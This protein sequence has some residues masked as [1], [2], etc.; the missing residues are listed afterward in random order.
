MKAFLLSA[1]LGTRLKPI[2]DVIPKC[3]LT[4]HGKPLLY[5]WFKLFAE[6][7]ITE[8]LINLHHLPKRVIEGIARYSLWKF[9]ITIKLFYEP[10]LLG[11]AGT[12]KANAEWLNNEDF[13]IAYADNL[14][15]MDIGKMHK[16]HK[17]KN[18]I[19]TLWLYHSDVPKECG[20]ATLDSEDRIIEFIEKPIEPKSDL[21]SAGLYIATRGLFDY[22]PDGISDL[23][24]DVLPKM[25]ESG[26]AYGY[27]GKG[28]VRGVGTFDGYDKAEREWLIKES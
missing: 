19:L 11:T 13:L 10:S 18:G 27:T 9:G 16:Y 20:I 3:M 12:I 17:Q 4:V 25:I 1:G 6:F 21:G 5:H 22:I 8:V 15:D 14:T 24:I 7:G 26:K 2:T 28:Y 23:S